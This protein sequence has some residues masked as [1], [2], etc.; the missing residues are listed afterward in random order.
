MGYRE[1]MGALEDSWVNINGEFVKGRE[2]TVSIWDRGFVYGDAVFEGVFILEG[3]VLKL[4]EHI[5]R[6]FESATYLAISVPVS[7][8]TLH[9]RVLE[10][11]RRNGIDEGY[12][13]PKI[14]RG[15]GPLGVSNTGLINE[16]ATA[17]VFVIPQPIKSMA[18]PAV[19]SKSARI[20]SIK[21]RSPQTLDPR[22]KVDNYLPNIMAEMEVDAS[23]ADIAIMLDQD[24]YITEANTANIFAI[25]DGQLLTPPHQSALAGITRRTVLE[26]SEERDIIPTSIHQLTP[27]DLY[28]ADEV[29]ITGTSA[30]IVQVTEINGRQIGDGAVGEITETLAQS[31]Y[32]HLIETGTPTTE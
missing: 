3:R 32:D 6:L 21:Q 31:L 19:E 26:L 10:T 5:D 23:A 8:E 24:G 18:L 9:S 15:E 16:N 20:V 4:E 25:R 22:A 2:A 13:R 30:G 14:S 27:Y 12:V 28:T 17:N 7:K 1:A 29:F 11:V